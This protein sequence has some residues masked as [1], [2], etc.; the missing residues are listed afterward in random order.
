MKAWLTRILIT[1]SASASWARV[2]MPMASTASPACMVVTGRPL[3]EQLL[4]HVGEVVFL[5]AVFIV[6]LGQAVHEVGALEEVDGGVHL[7]DQLDRLGGVP[8]F[9]DPGDL[10]VGTAHHPPVAGR[11]FQLHGEDGRAGPGED[12]AVDKA[13]EGG[14]GDEGRVA[15][16]HQDILVLRE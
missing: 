6:Q 11:V 5:L 2:L 12:E 13:L 8:L 7:S 15:H 10:A 9:H 4:H 1:R 3:L 16:Q 14:L